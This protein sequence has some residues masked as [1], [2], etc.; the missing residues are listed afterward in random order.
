MKLQEGVKKS[1]TL[2]EVC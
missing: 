1:K 2:L